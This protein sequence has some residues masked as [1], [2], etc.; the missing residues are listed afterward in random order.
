M[1]VFRVQLVFEV[2]L[3][4]EPEVDLVVAPEVDLVVELVVL[5]AAVLIFAAELVAVLVAVPDPDLGLVCCFDLYC[6]VGFVGDCLIQRVK[7][8]L[9]FYSIFFSKRFSLLCSSLSVKSLLH[10]INVVLFIFVCLRFLFKRCLSSL[11][12]CFSLF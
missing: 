1:V 2:E 12:L 6:A 11:R 7:S 5:P 8:C 9:C 3:A 4:V 10:F